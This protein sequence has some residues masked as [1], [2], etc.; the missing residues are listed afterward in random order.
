MKELLRKAR[1]RFTMYPRI[2]GNPDFLIC[3]DI[4]VFCDS[5]FWHGRNWKKLKAQLERGSDPSYWVAHI[6]GNRDRDR[7]VNAFLRKIGYRVLRF[8]DHEVFKEPE[9]CLRRIKKAMKQT[10]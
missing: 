1:I 10:S 7:R 2:M 4:V 8:W 5:S 6:A 3:E 9:G